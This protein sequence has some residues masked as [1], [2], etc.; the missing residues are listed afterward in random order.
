MDIRRWENGKAAASLNSC[1]LWENLSRLENGKISALIADGAHLDQG[2]HI[3]DPRPRSD[4]HRCRN[5]IHPERY[6]GR[7][8]KAFTPSYRWP[9]CEAVY[10]EI[11]PR[12]PRSSSCVSLSVDLTV[13]WCSGE[14][15]RR[16]AALRIR[17]YPMRHRARSVRGHGNRSRSVLRPIKAAPR[18]NERFRSS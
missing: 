7:K 9:A 18:P 5:H 14:L 6:R 12:L 15:R 3:P 8:R 11:V 10:P 16:G 17:G 1:R 13:N 4:R 2:Q